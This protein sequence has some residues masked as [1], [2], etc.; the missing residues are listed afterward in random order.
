MAVLEDVTE[1]APAADA[2]QRAASGDGAGADAGEQ[3]SRRPPRQPPMN[4]APS[5]HKALTEY[6]DIVRRTVPWLLHPQRS[7]PPPPG[8]KWPRV[9]ADGKIANQA[10]ALE[11]RAR[12]GAKMLAALGAAPVKTLAETV[13]SE[14]KAALLETA[15]KLVRTGAATDRFMAQGVFEPVC[16]LLLQGLP[17]WC[18]DREIALRSLDS[19]DPSH[20]VLNALA[21]AVMTLAQARRPMHEAMLGMLCASLQNVSVTCRMADDGSAARWMGSPAFRTV[22]DAN[23]CDNPRMGVHIQHLVAN[24]LACPPAVRTVLA[25]GK[26]A[27]DALVMAAVR[28]AVATKKGAEA[29]DT[30]PP[31]RA[32]VIRLQRAAAAATAAGAAAEE[33]GEDADAAAAAA[34]AKLEPATAAGQQQQQQQGEQQGEQQDEQPSQEQRERLPPKEVQKLALQV[35][36]ASFNDIKAELDAALAQ[37]AARKMKDLVV[38][39]DLKDKRNSIHLLDEWRKHRGFPVGW[40]GASH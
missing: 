9:G 37:D 38:V 17:G 20:D 23:C 6:P 13:A 36:Q 15:A 1:E 8:E 30:P 32:H 35:L 18:K 21:A 24:A 28:A 19:G 29:G 27:G 22:L 2:P 3:S 40:F 25:R 39:I 14:E 4:D 34:I 33:E 5:A 7:G 12:E 16:M 11:V 26:P 31:A 10:D